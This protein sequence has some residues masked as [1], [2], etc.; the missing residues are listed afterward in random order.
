MRSY[1]RFIYFVFCLVSFW[2][3]GASQSCPALTIPN[4][5]ITPAGPYAAGTTAR[6]DCNRGFV[7]NGSAIMTCPANG[8]W[9]TIT[10][11]QVPFGCPAPNITNGALVP[12]L[13]SYDAFA[14][15]T[16]TCNTGF[17]LVGSNAA[18]CANGQWSSQ[19][20]QCRRVLECPALTIPNGS[21]TPA[22]P[23]A[24]GTTATVDCNRGFVRNGSAIMT[25]PTDGK[26]K[27]ITNCQVPFGCPAPSIT[28]GALVP[29]L[30]SYDAF[31]RVTFTCNSGFTLVGNSVAVCANGQ[32][33][34][35]SPECRSETPGCPPLPALANGQTTPS[36][37]S[38]S[39]G[40]T[41]SFSCS[42]GYLLNGTRHLS[43]M[44]NN[45]WSAAPPTCEKFCIMPPP[46]TNGQVILKNITHSPV[47]SVAVYI[48]GNGFVLSSP[49]AL[50][51]LPSGRWSPSST[52]TRCQPDPQCA[53]SPCLNGGTCRN[54]TLNTGLGNF[55]CSCTSGRVGTKCQASASSAQT[56]Q[57]VLPGNYKPEYANTSSNEFQLTS[58]TIKLV[59]TLFFTTQGLDVDIVVTALL[60]GSVVVEFSVLPSSASAT[61][62]PAVVN[63][64]LSKIS[65][66][67]LF[68]MLSSG[69]GG[70][71]SPRL[72]V[73]CQPPPLVPNSPI[74]LQVTVNDTFL[75]VT[76]EVPMLVC[77]CN[78]RGTCLWEESIVNGTDKYG[79]VQCNCEAAYDGVN[80]NEDAN[81]CAGNPCFGNC[82][83]V[84]APQSGFTCAPCPAHLTGNG[85]TCIDRDE[86]AEGTDNCAQN[87]T[88]VV[89][90]FNCSCHAGFM[91]DSSNSS[92]C[93][94]VN[95]CTMNPNICAAGGSA[96]VC[97]DTEGSYMCS[98]RSGYQ[99]DASGICVDIPDCNNRTICDNTTS[100]CQET[101]GSYECACKMGYS[102]PAGKSPQSPC[103]NT[104]EC[105]ISPPVCSVGSQCSDLVGSFQCDCLPGH[106][107]ISSTLCSVNTTS[108]ANINCTTEGSV[109]N[110]H[111]SNPV[112]CDC[113]PNKVKQ[114]NKCRA[115]YKF[116]QR[117][118]DLFQLDFNNLN[119]PASQ[120]FIANFKNLMRQLLAPI[121]YADLIVTELRN[122]S[123]IVLYDLVMNET[124]P[125]V[126]QEQ[127]LV[128]ISQAI[129]S[130]QFNTSLFDGAPASLT[131][132]LDNMC[133]KKNITQLN[134]Q[135][136]QN[137]AFTTSLTCQP[138]LVG[139]NIDYCNLTNAGIS[140]A[141]LVIAGPGP[142]PANVDAACKPR[143]LSLPDGKLTVTFLLFDILSCGVR[144]AM[145]QETI[146]LSYDVRNMPPTTGVIQRYF[147][148]CI[149]FNCTFNRTAQVDFSPIDPRIEKLALDA[150]SGAG[151]FDISMNLFRDENCT[152]PFQSIGANPPNVLV[153]EYI[154]FK[155]SINRHNAHMVLQAPK[156]WATP[157][158]DPRSMQK[159]DIIQEG[160]ASAMDKPNIK[161]VKNYETYYISAGVASFIWTNI[162]DQRIYIHC[163]VDVC[164]NTSGSCSGP[165]CPSRRK[166]FV[167][168]VNHPNSKLYSIGPLKIVS[169]CDELE[170]QTCSQKCVV[171]NGKPRC[172]CMDGF[173]LSTDGRTCIF[174]GASLR[175]PVPIQSENFVSMNQIL[176]FVLFMCVVCLI[177]TR[178][179]ERKN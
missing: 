172:S 135:A 99:M 70:D 93:V 149:T 160:C 63:T 124:A 109:C 51:C 118:R 75:E 177:I 146:T 43:C 157:T 86:C 173:Y 22:G 136:L 32:W 132:H 178:V 21:I 81:G 16:F 123:V 1:L 107:R 161:V 77:D 71:F 62:D 73:D 168:Q 18:L 163:E 10:N 165:T 17:T 7:R 57:I 128:V 90:S 13:A 37:P 41:V 3:C 60:E 159:Y 179:R 154:Y 175:N 176:I 56:H 59:L 131:T 14:R 50:T 91:V 96:A 58:N 66:S 85:T 94:N 170:P 38:T 113:P 140:P 65:A 153:E 129:A 116:Q 72:V 6:V 115:H 152:M 78:N 26:W 100:L 104:N 166:R 39:V 110:E 164:Y 61:L 150:Q 147:D 2:K 97:L 105:T 27:T 126:S 28:N 44:A 8:Q 82:I 74:A 31:A 130:G 88:N 76:V 156:C 134:L 145:D 79:L 98:C 117:L 122:G 34:S 138:S 9:T 137:Q 120:L 155:A 83:D 127:V 169:A 36:T 42:P 24:A 49:S 114:G 45:M 19:P 12:A 25:C 133:P 95:E 142:L 15:V 30:A 89:N 33:S 111:G 68:R 92:N 103:T 143:I 11:C 54:V 101:P 5:S 112:T 84:P 29:A 108:C 80:C 121:N 87:C 67:E 162:T 102:R 148:A 158:A 52:Q 125:V 144:T 23:Y 174:D 171:M 167:G 48:C 4:G 20:P 106:S 139:I 69:N 141:D 46:V 151:R 64:A 119:S 35:Q 55:K 47:G 40:S 53:S